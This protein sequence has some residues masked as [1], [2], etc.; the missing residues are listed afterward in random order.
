[1]HAP[2]KASIK[3]ENHKQCKEVSGKEFVDT[4]LECLRND[5]EKQ[6]AVVGKIKSVGPWKNDGCWSYSGKAGTLYRFEGCIVAED[7]TCIDIDSFQNPAGMTMF[8]ISASEAERCQEKLQRQ[9]DL[10]SYDQTYRFVL[11]A[12][13]Y[14]GEPMTRCGKMEKVKI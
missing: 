14:N 3:R 2:F 6:S 7:G 10:I 13:E 12:S 11:G 5:H 9:Y 1:M 4:E 8:G